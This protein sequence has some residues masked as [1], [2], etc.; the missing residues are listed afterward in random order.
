MNSVEKESARLESR[1]EIIVVGR[2]ILTGRTLDE[3]SN[4]MAKKITALGGRVHKITCV[5]DD[6]DDIAYE[7]RAAAKRDARIIITTGG[8]GTTRDDMTLEG[9]AM[10]FNTSLEINEGALCFIKNRYKT[11]YDKGYVDTPRMTASRKKMAMIPKNSK[12]LSNS[13]G[14]APGVLFERKNTAVFSL[15]GVPAEMQAIFDEHVV[16]YLRRLTANRAWVEE[17]VETNFKD[18]SKLGEIIKKVMDEISG[19]YLK[20]AVDRFGKDV[21]I[22]VFISAFGEDEEKAKDLIERAKSELLKKL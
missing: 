13:V 12:W 17:K 10:A 1:I 21:R 15:P 4:W 8:L 9:A 16:P 5:D 14:A 18:E 19:A 6:L 20:S 11:F 22:E 3:N 2:E 7:I